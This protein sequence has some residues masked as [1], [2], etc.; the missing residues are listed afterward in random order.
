M[1]T[2]QHAVSLSV[3]AAVLAGLLFGLHSTPATAAVA[4]LSSTQYLRGLPQL[5]RD[6]GMVQDLYAYDAN[7]NVTAITD[8]QEGVSSRA[9]G[10]DG[11]DRLTAA[12]GNWGAGSFGYDALDNLRTSTVGSR[13]AVATIDAANRLSAL[14]ING[15]VQAFGYDANGN[16]TQRGAQAFG[17]DIGNRLTSAPGKASY[18][19]DGHGRRSWVAYA[20]GSWKLQVYSQS[21]KLLYSQHSSQGGTWHIY[22]GE[23]LIAENYTATGV[24]TYLHTDALG[25]P[26]ARTNASGQIISRTRYEPYGATAAGTNPTGIGFTGHV[27]D[28]DTGLV[29]MQQRYYEPVAGRFLSVDPVTTSDKDGSFFGRYHYANNNPYKFKDPNGTAPI[30]IPEEVGGR[31]PLI[32][33]RNLDGTPYRLSIGEGRANLGEARARLQENAALG[34]GKYEVGAHGSLK[35]RSTPG[36]GIEIH[37]AAQKH[38]AGQAISG[39]DPKTGPS[40]ALP[41]GEH[42]DIPTMKGE[43]SGSARDLLAKDIRDLRNSTSAPNSSLRELIQLNKDM[44]P[45]AFGK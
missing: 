7:A 26:V 19:Y 32:G 4:T 38:P 11:L 27:N 22:L 24:P 36:D 41:R 5:W 25:S 44:Y 35:G 14:N 40:I 16:L 45:G 8:Q 6:A 20:D 15:A 30:L 34:V 43:Y 2:S 37:H 23:R 42:R 17:F 39:Y 31:M 18:I 9:M 28:A 12:N 13:S 10:Y 3:I 33:G 1:P 29:Y 21:G